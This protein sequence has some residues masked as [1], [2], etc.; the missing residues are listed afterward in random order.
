[1]DIGALLLLLF[2]RFSGVSQTRFDNFRIFRILKKK[3]EEIT[4]VSSILVVGE[5]VKKCNSNSTL[6][7]LST[8]VVIRSCT[9]FRIICLSV[10][11]LESHMQFYTNDYM[12]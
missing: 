5:Q 7:S 3:Y 8:A 11:R 10:H 4:S 6:R 12:N 9:K 2:E 1:M